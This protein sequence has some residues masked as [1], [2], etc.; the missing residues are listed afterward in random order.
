M[1]SA[2]WER[3]PRKELGLLWRPVQGVVLG[4]GRCPVC[5][6]SRYICFHHRLLSDM[7]GTTCVVVSF[8]K[9]HVFFT[10]LVLL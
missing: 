6:A 10:H 2:K 8:Y 3:T 4:V 7:P 1:D 9:A 5:S